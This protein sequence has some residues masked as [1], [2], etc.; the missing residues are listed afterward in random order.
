MGV[1]NAGLILKTQREIYGKTLSCIKHYMPLSLGTT[2]TG[3]SM[4]L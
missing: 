2:R 3:S 4:F 1:V